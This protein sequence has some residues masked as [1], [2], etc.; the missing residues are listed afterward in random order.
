[1]IE[2]SSDDPREFL[3]KG[4]PVFISTSQTFHKNSCVNKEVM[5]QLSSPSCI[6]PTTIQDALTKGS[7]AC[8]LCFWQELDD[9]TLFREKAERRESP[10][11]ARSDD[12]ADIR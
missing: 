4:V 1:M 6:G 12:E 7:K 10:R 2:Q 11:P 5:Y 8:K 9:G 3:M